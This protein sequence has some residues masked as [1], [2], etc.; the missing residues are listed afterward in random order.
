MSGIHLAALAAAL[1]FPLAA[2]PQVAAWPGAPAAPSPAPLPGG[3]RFIR[4]TGE[5]RVSVR[6]DVAV[7]VA[8]VE[9]TGKDLALVTKD[10][11]AQMRRVMAALTQLEIAEKDIQTT[12]HDV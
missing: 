10:A 8:G 2:R 4:V 5:G 7:L 9:S 12:R 1:A 3:P 6:P 11:A